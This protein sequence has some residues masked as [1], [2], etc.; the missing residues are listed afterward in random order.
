MQHNI[1]NNSDSNFLASGPTA[2]QPPFVVKFEGAC[3]DCGGSGYDCGSLNPVEP[4]ECPGCHGSGKQIIV[5]NY[6]AEA[7]RIA[8]GRSATCPQ[9]E[10][11]QA[12]IQHCRSI[13]GALMALS[14]IR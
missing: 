10:H 3:E 9:Q 8:A 13:V 5:R 14:Q 12:V 6:L 7:F 4:E 11:L 1:E 2:T